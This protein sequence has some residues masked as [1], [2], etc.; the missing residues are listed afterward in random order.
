MATTYNISAYNND[1][2]PGVNFTV[3]VNTV[4]LNLTDATIRMQVRKS[5]NETP[6]LDLALG[7]GLT[8]TDAA[9][10]KFKIDEQIISGT[11]GMYYYDIEI[12][13]SG[14][15]VKTYIKGTFTIVGDVTHV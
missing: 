7:T 6:I 9:A 13:L 8:I 3:T 1:T 10:G 12:T 11:P 15:D 5:R 4:V 14:G 2:F